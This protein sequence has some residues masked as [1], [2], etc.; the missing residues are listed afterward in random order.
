MD[1][2]DIEFLA[3]LRDELLTQPTDGNRNPR[4]WGIRQKE[5]IWGIDSEFADGWGVYDGENCWYVGE[6]NNLQSVLDEL[7]DPDAYGL[8]E[9]A[10]EGWDRERCRR[11]RKRR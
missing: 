7:L 5:L 2:K 6:K 8:T 11:C 9:D 4:F 3:R 1:K 10:F